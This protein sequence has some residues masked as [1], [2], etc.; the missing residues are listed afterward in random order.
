MKTCSSC[1]I[2][3]S[4]DDF[5]KRSSAKDGHTNLCKPCKREYDNNHYKK[6]EYRRNYIR[7]NQKRRELETNSY[8]L[9]YL[10]NHPCV[11]CGETDPVVL[12]FDH[13]RGEKKKEISILKRS[14]LKAVKRE[15]EKCEVRCANCHRRKTAVQFN[16]K[17]KLASIA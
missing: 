10:N 6:N 14:S 8:I 15:I 3:K 16:W 12:E 17:N 1:G 5:Q 9:E 7:E 2:L 13:V 11:D 4:L